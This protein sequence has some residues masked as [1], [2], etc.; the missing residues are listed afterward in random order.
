MSMNTVLLKNI[1]RGPGLTVIAFD[2]ELS[3][4]IGDVDVTEPLGSGDEERTRSGRVMMP[5]PEAT[6]HERHL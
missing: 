4:L 6:E 5:L 2:P 3:A 1:G